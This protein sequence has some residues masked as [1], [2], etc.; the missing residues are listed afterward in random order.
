M[1]KRVHLDK[2]EQIFLFF[3]TFFFFAW[4]LALA[5]CVGGPCAHTH[6]QKPRWCGV[7]VTGKKKKKVRFYTFFSV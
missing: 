7:C 6:A 4:R 1:P 5:L 2:I 3:L